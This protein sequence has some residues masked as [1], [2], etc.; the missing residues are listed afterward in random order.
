MSGYN[1]Y[2]TL[3]FPKR[4]KRK[5]EKLENI[6]FIDPGLGG[7]GWAFY[8]IL[9]TNGKRNPQCPHSSGS[10][11]PKGSADWQTKAEAI[12]S[13]FEGHLATF[14]INAL[15]M[16]APEAWLTDSTGL[17]SVQRG[18]VFKLMYLIGGLADIARRRGI[19]VPIILAPREWKGQLPKAVTEK[20]VRKAFSQSEWAPQ[21]K[22]SHEMDAVGMGLA[23]Q[24]AL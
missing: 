4:G 14:Q 12:W 15:V 1:Q 20:R 5:N 16:E 2:Q 8:S 11:K 24:G 6:M 17:A 10:F 9:P 13:W 21:T 23:A 3:M 7:T 19:R 22:T 18:D